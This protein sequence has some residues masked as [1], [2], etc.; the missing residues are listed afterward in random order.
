MI[1]LKTEL[2]IQSVLNNTEKKYD[3]I[4]SY[5]GA[6]LDLNNNINAKKVCKAFFTSSPAWVDKLF[7]FRNKIVSVFGLKIAKESGDKKKQLD[8]F[9]CEAGEQLGLFKVFSSA[10]NEVIIGEDDKHLNFRVSLF[11][12]N[13]PIEKNKKNITITTSAEFNNWFGRLYFLP[14]KPFHKI[15]VPTML[16]AI[17]K[18]LEATNA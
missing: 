6:V 11:I 10:E 4:D 2:P 3:F 7:T 17:I 18:E 13:H 5:I 8:N 16:K 14:V 9:N 12:E 1:V 15:I